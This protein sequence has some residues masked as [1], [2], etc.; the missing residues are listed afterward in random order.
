MGK[1]ADMSMWYDTKDGIEAALDRGLPGFKQL[2]DERHTAGYKRKERLGEWF[3]LHGR[4]WLDSCGNLMRCTSKIWLPDMVTAADDDP[5]SRTK[6]R[7]YTPCGVPSGSCPKCR[8]S[9][10]LNEAHQARE[11]RPEIYGGAWTYQHRSCEIM[12]QVARGICDLQTVWSRGLAKAN[13]DVS[14]SL[15]YIPNGYWPSDPN[16]ESEFPQDPWA[17]ASTPWGEVEFGGR[18]RVWEIDWSRAPGL[19]KIKGSAVVSKP[20]VTHAEH[21]VHCWDDDDLVRVLG[22]LLRGPT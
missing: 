20:N 7:A 5:N 17:V 8:R 1:G 2:Y 3:I 16:D 15:R 9:W 12:D 21:L 13:A 10:S 4:F 22:I 11:I 18:K 19:A 14:T 6:G